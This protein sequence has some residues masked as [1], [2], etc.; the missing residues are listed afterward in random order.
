VTT[1]A[2][3]QPVAWIVVYEPV[4]SENA[5]IDGSELFVAVDLELG[6]VGVRPW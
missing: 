5:L 2:S 6:T 1:R 4:P 3:K